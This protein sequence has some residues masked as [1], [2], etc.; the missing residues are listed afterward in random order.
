M[1]RVL[2]I[3]HGQSSANVSRTLAGRIPNV[4]L[5]ETGDRQARQIASALA[6]TELL[7]VVASPLLRTVQTARRIAAQHSA[8]SVRRDNAFNEVDYGQWSGKKL[9][10]LA[11]QPLWQQIQQLPSSVTFPGGESMAGAHRRATAGLARLLDAQVATDEPATLAIVSH[12]D[13]IKMLLADAMGLHLD[14]FQRLNVDPAST[15]CV[16]A[17][18]AISR[19]EFMNV[20]PS[21]LP[22][23]IG[24]A[25]G[26]S[27]VGGSTGPSQGSK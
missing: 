12:A 4:H 16:L 24:Q 2:L 26:A 25:S 10:R 20:P 7:A 14:Q 18:D 21:G 3:R 6:Q 1:I 15:S 23:V 9:A 17:G 5:S 8:L 22:E 13:I 11:K 19:V 27:L